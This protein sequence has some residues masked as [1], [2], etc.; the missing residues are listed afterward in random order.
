MVTAGARVDSKL[1]V[2]L[3]IAN[4]GYLWRTSERGEIRAGLGIHFAELEVG[5][6][7]TVFANGVIVS[8]GFAQEDLLAP[9]PNIYLGGRYALSPKWLAKMRL[10]WLSLS[11]QDWDGDLLTLGAQLEY[12]VSKRIGVGFG[13]TNEDFD[14]THEDSKGKERYELDMTGPTLYLRANF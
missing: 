1:G 12:T 3:L 8:Q 14:V 2:K 6:G 4:F 5:I 11:Y 10:G 7:A 13:Y 9:L